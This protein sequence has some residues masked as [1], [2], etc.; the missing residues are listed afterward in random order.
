VPCREVSN[1]NT[2]TRHI[3]H[4]PYCSTCG[5]HEAVVSNLALDSSVMHA[6]TVDRRLLE[7]AL[8]GSDSEIGDDV[9]LGQSAAF[10]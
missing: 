6:V 3:P 2:Q 7:D 5:S 8:T 10:F 4:Q 9:N 1:A